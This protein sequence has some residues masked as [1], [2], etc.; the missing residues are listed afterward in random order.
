MEKFKG[1]SIKKIKIQET[2]TYLVITL[3][4]ISPL[5]LP[6]PSREKKREKDAKQIPSVIR[7]PLNVKEL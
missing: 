6:L 3:F 4:K 7:N 2:A 1:K 5:L